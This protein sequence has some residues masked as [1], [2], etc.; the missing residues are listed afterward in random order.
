MGVSPAPIA[1]GRLMADPG[2]AH[3]PTLA[4]AGSDQSVARVAPRRAA[5]RVGR[6]ER[7]VGRGRDRPMLLPGAKRHA[8]IQGAAQDHG[9]S[10]A[11][12][13]DHDRRSPGAAT[14]V[15]A[16]ATRHP[17]GSATMPDGVAAHVWA[18]RRAAVRATQG[19]RV[20][21]GRIEAPIAGPRPSGASSAARSAAVPPEQVSSAVLTAGPRPSDASSAAVPPDPTPSA[22]VPPEPA[23]S[24]AV[25]PEPA[26]SAAPSAAVPPRGLAPGRRAAGPVASTTAGGLRRAMPL[27]HPSD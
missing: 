1:V 10:V 19:G 26:S 4:L 8:S 24:A 2:P 16:R 6:R 25:P 7:R 13:P 20:D 17:M 27:H 12:Q 18:A 23:P 14:T 15:S 11:V 21:R 9:M 22:A 3:A 5:S